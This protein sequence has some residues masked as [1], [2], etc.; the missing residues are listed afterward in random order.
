M[1]QYWRSKCDAMKTPAPHSSLGHSRLRRVIL[2]FSSTCSGDTHGRVRTADRQ[3][4]RHRQTDRQTETG[5]EQWGDVGTDSPLPRAV[6]YKI[7]LQP[8]EAGTQ[9]N[10]D[11]IHGHSLMM[12]PASQTILK[13]KCWSFCDNSVSPT[14]HKNPIAT[15]WVQQT[16][17]IYNK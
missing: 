12:R 13:S 8:H 3:T 1:P 16:E 6:S 2:P 17:N 10:A 11:N 15:I 14:R 9:M 5:R 4:D 7:G